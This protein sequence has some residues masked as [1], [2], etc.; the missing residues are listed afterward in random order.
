MTFATPLLLTLIPLI[1]AAL[2]WRFQVRP[3]AKPALLTADLG[4]LDAAGRP[5][6][7]QTSVFLGPKP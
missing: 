7:S 3:G 5:A 4:M 6:T 1:A 2:Y